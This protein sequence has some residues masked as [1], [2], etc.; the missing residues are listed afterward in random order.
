MCNLLQKNL[1]YDFIIQNKLEMCLS[2]E[3]DLTFIH[4]FFFAGTILSWYFKM[5]VKELKEIQKSRYGK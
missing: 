1:H 3:F 4:F 5:A 2:K